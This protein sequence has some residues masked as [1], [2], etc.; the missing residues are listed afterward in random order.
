MNST[1][2][3]EIIIKRRKS[4]V[5]KRNKAKWVVKGSLCY[6]YLLSLSLH[7]V[8]QPSLFYFFLYIPFFFS[9]ISLLCCRHF[10]F[11]STNLKHIPHNLES[12][13]IVSS[14]D[15]CIANIASKQR[16]CCSGNLSS[17]VQCLPVY[18]LQLILFADET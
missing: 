1:K 7:F 2:F 10:S 11:F 16:P 4:Q 5:Q 6:S 3:K 14:V 18:D 9:I 13:W 12:V 17:N 15:S 8:I